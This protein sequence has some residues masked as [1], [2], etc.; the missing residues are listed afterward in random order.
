MLRILFMKKHPR[1][2]FKNQQFLPFQSKKAGLQV[3]CRSSVYW[4]CVTFYSLAPYN[5]ILNKYK[6]FV[7]FE[8]NQ[9]A[10]FSILVTEFLYILKT[11]AG[12]KKRRS[13]L[14]LKKI[15]YVWRAENN[16]CCLK[17]ETYAD[18]EKTLGLR[19]L[20]V[21][22]LATLLISSFLPE[23]QERLQYQQIL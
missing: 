9:F 21:Q 5:H 22:P 14:K 13:L 7:S 12:R 23:R 11:L 20:Y 3:F 2:S 16:S 19:F 1:F 17:K 6:S 8:Q 18:V 15:A 10:Q 4:I